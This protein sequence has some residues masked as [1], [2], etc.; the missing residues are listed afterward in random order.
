MAKSVL[1]VKLH[2]RW[3]IKRTESVTETMY[4]IWNV[5]KMKALNNSLPSLL[6]QL[7]T[8]RLE[9]LRSFQCAFDRRASA[10]N[11][12]SINNL[13]S[14]LLHFIVYVTA[15]LWYEVVSLFPFH[16]SGSIAHA[17]THTYSRRH[18][19]IYLHTHIL[20]QVHTHTY[21][22]TLAWYTHIHLHRVG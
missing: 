10:D 7:T 3:R 16:P 5:G 22:N 15:F 6:L 1:N 21:I 18:T 19:H 14:Q 11:I 20:I 12:Y 8:Y 9:F 4:F 2:L 13:S 17:F